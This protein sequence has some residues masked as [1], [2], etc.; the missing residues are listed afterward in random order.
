MGLI[1]V[2]LMVY[3][4]LASFKLP[5]RESKISMRNSPMGNLKEARPK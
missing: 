5:I 3:F 1:L 2:F 4:G